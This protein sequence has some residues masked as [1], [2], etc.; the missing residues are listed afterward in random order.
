[1][2]YYA[3]IEYPDCMYDILFRETPKIIKIS[4]NKQAILDH[5][6]PIQKDFLKYIESHA[7]MVEKRRDF[8]KDYK[9]NTQRIQLPYFYND[10]GEKEMWPDHLKF[11][12]I[13]KKQNPWNIHIVEVN[14]GLIE[15]LK[16]YLGS[17]PIFGRLFGDKSKR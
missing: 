1:M 5:L 6:D 4:N 13:R 12:N 17:F 7:I 16:S 8:I 2:K 15:I 3:L 14:L 10:S 11:P 9:N